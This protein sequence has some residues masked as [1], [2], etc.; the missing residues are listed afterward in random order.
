MTTPRRTALAMLAG[1]ALPGTGSMHS[2]NS[3]RLGG[4]RWSAC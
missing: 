1:L 2:A 4:A 3:P